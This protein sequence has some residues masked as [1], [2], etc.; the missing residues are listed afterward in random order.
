MF[1]LAGRDLNVLIDRVL[2]ARIRPHATSAGW[3]PVEVAVPSHVG[4][5]FLL[6]LENPGSNVSAFSEV[7]V[8][9][10][11]RTR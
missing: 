2:V 6:E 9:H 11:H 5:T 7:E 1:R 3:V 4:D 10:A 8:D